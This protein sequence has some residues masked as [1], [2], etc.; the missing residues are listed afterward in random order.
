MI[1]RHFLVKIK[2]FRKKKLTLLKHK[3]RVVIKC[4][5]VYNFCFNE[6]NNTFTFQKTYRKYKIKFTDN[7]ISTGGIE[8]INLENNDKEIM[9]KIYVN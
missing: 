9:L 3:I 2:D 8:I 5:T 6:S 1:S 4:Y 7:S